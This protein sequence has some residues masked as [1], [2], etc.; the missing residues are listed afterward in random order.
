MKYRIRTQFYHGPQL[1]SWWWNR[2]QGRWELEES[3]ATLY[4]TKEE[5]ESAAFNEVAK[6][7]MTGEITVEVVD[8][9][10]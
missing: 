6:R 10:R 4:D 5:A 3:A 9:G 7:G 8:D 2:E 1:Y